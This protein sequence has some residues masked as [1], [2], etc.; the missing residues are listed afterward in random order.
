[1]RYRHFGTNRHNHLFKVLRTLSKATKTP[2]H[3]Y[4]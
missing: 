2:L 3:L 1:L 4:I